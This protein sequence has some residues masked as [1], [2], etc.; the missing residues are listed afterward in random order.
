MLARLLGD[1]HDRVVAVDILHSFTQ[2]DNQATPVI[3]E[4]NRQENLLL[5]SARIYLEK[6]I[7]WKTST[8][9]A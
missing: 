6:F 8:Q 5:G 7:R 2:L 9:Q 3:I 4:L 1:W